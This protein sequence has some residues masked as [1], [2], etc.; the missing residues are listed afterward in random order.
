MNYNGKKIAITG[1]SG[2]LG[3]ALVE[4]FAGPTPSSPLIGAV[5]DMISSFV[6]D[7]RQAK[8]TLEVI[9]GDV[10]D[11]KT[12]SHLDHT[13][14]YLFH[15]A[16]PSS[17]VLF[18]RNPA[19]CIDSTMGGLINAARACQKHGIRLIY[20]STG[21]L[22]Q[23][24]Y[25]EYA[26]CKKLSEEYVRGLGID[27]LGIRIFATYGPGEGHK[28]DYASVPYL[29]ARD[30]VN[31]RRPLIYGDGKQV[32]DF[33][34]IDDVVK[35]IAI[36]AEECNDPVVDLGSG[37]QHSFNDI[38]REIVVSFDGEVNPEYIDA[39]AGYVQET[40]AKPE[41]LLKYY[42]PEIGFAEGIKRVVDHLK[43]L[44]K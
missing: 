26:M 28:R 33:I 2:F 11:P 15:F 10:R 23:D 43:E 16:A 19:H 21:L 18:K 41:T 1:A 31:G 17:Q 20:P 12:F 29:L 24:R 27:A 32:R 36:L 37:E 3:G 39:P 40:A 22:S 35:A 13:Y 8:P 6:G 38:L 4:H 5:Y 25:N 14:D 9:D 30:V 7:R 34:Y 42:T 44:K